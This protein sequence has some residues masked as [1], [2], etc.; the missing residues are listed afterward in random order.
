M[1]IAQNTFIDLP[2]KTTEKCNTEKIAPKM[3]KGKGCRISSSE[4]MRMNERLNVLTEK[5]I[6]QKQ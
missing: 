3:S 4:Y 5:R 6:H 1:K 2:E